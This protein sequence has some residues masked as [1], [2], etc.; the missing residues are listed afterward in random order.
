L[1]PFFAVISYWL[2]DLTNEKI[3]LLSNYV[4][5]ERFAIFSKVISER[6][7]Y[8]TVVL[9]DIFQSQNASAVIRTCDCFGVQNVHAIENRNKFDVNPEVSL[10]SSKWV[11][12]YRYNKNEKNSAEALLKLKADGYRIIATTPHLNDVDLHNFDVTKGKC[13]FI[14]GTELKGISDVVKTYADEFMKIPMYGFTESFNISVSAA[15]ILHHITLKLRES[16]ID[17][18]LNSDEQNELL[19]RWLMSNIK[20]SSFIVKNYFSEK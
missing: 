4:T 11:N 1:F 9:E 5:E 19:L 14:F 16:K 6:T 3:K 10:G 2:M 7:N 15:I 8:I 20:G 12:L 18:R 17:W 13:A